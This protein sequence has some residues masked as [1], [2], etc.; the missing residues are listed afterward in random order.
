MEGKRLDETEEAR[1]DVAVT[2]RFV[3]VVDFDTLNQR[4]GR[5][6]FTYVPCEN[7]IDGMREMI[8]RGYFSGI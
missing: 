4:F 8:S 2:A 3:A 5:L 7:V 1:F 6:L